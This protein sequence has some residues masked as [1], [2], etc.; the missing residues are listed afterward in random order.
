MKQRTGRIWD[1]TWIRK[2]GKLHT[3]TGCRGI[4]QEAAKDRVGLTV[5]DTKGMRR[6]AA[7]GDGGMKGNVGEGG[8]GRLDGNREHVKEPEREKNAGR[9][10]DLSCS[11]GVNICPSPPIPCHRGHQSG[12][13]P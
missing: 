11:H 10:S 4:S 13:V 8:N 9:G 5:G 7:G 2:K 12:A 3:H 1:I 6:K